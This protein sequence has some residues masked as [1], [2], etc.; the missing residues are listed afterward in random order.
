[1]KWL[2]GA[3]FGHGHP[4]YITDCMRTIHLRTMKQRAQESLESRENVDAIF[5]FVGQ[6]YVIW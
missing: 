3:Y 6:I 2:I 1:M 5:L 4:H